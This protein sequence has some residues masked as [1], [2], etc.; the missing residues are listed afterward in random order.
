MPAQ[1][2]QRLVGQHRPGKQIT[3]HGGA[4]MHNKE[5]ALALRLHP[6]GNHLQP[7]PA[8]QP[9]QRPRD[10]AAIPIGIDGAGEAAIDLDAVNRKAG[11]VGERGI[12]GAKTSMAS[13][14]PIARNASS[15]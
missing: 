10:Q 12:A 11:E 9:D 5:A 2:R 14:Q 1:P 4:A 3:L 7:Q 15:V 13:V 8:P 6:F